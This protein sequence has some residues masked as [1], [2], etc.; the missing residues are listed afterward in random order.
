MKNKFIN[1]ARNVWDRAVTL[2][3]RVDQLWISLKT[4]TQIQLSFDFIVFKSIW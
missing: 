3:P 1:H 2:L 4:I